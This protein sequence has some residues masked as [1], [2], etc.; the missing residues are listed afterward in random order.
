MTRLAVSQCP[1]GHHPI[2]SGP[3]EG[4]L[5]A[6]VMAALPWHLRWKTR[7]HLVETSTPLAELQRKTLRG[8]ATWHQN[9]AAA[10]HACGGTAVIFSNELVD[11][12]PVRR[13]D[14]PGR[15]AENRRQ[16]RPRR[17]RTGIVH[18]LHRAAG[19]V[20]IFTLPPERTAH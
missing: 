14:P 7:L 4:K 12:F 16:L 17:M 6:A 10:L 20:R 9:P 5:A 18:D 19:L 2:V 13:F 11:A 8:K 15:M 3:G 1:N